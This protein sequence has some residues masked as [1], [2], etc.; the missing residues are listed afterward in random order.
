MRYALSAAP[1]FD[2]NSWSRWETSAGGVDFHE[3]AKCYKQ[4]KI[5]VRDAQAHCQ[6]CHGRDP[7]MYTMTYQACAA[8]VVQDI[9][10][11]NQ[12]CSLTDVVARCA[13]RFG[14]REDAQKAMSHS[15]KFSRREL[16]AH[17]A[18][19][20]CVVYQNIIISNGGFFA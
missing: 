1:D 17:N 2:Q 19:E 20:E 4:H 16:C 6:Q 13:D 14:M 5:S 8:N 7:I 3:M 15:D 12:S 11:L 9:R 10:D 18:E